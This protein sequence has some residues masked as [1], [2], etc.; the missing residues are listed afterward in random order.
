MRNPSIRQIKALQNL[1]QGMSKRQ[2]MIKAGYSLS[3]ANQAARVFDK[4]SMKNLLETY[5]ELF[6][7]AGI[8]PAYIVGKF[9]E[10][11]NSENE[12]VQLKAYDR[13]EKIMG[14]VGKENQKTEGFKRTLTIQEFVLGTAEPNDAEF[15]GGF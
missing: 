11:L 15:N 3:T 7:K 6:E 4:K 8:N 1:A 5:K 13:Y 14:I 9:S 10:W 2:A 12:E